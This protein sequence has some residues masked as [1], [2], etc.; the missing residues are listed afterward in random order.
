VTLYGTSTFVLLRCIFRAVESFEMFGNLGCTDNCGPILSNEWYLF[1]F[2]L[3]PMLIFT[4]WL[5]LLHPGR[6]LP[7]NKTRYLDTDGRTERMGPGWS[8]RRDPWETFIDPLDFQGKMKGQVS[9]DQY[10]LR[11]NEWSICEDGSF[12]K[13]TASNMKLRSASKERALQP[14]EV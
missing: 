11:P 10:W 5:N 12:A 6:Y 13:G 4:F 8:D 7:R 1:A 9:H 14:A 2:E 3:G